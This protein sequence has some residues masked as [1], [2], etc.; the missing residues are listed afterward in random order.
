V[1]VGMDDS[2]KEEEHKGVEKKFNDD[3]ESEVYN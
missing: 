2:A 3:L 1:F